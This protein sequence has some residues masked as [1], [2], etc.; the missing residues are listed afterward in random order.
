MEIAAR[1]LLI[2]GDVAIQTSGAPTAAMRTHAP[3]R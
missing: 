3:T 1:E 2:K